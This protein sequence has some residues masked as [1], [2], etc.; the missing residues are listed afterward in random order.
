MGA[1]CNGNAV[2]FLCCA[3][4]LLALLH[5]KGQRNKVALYGRYRAE[6]SSAK[7]LIPAKIGWFVQELPSFLVPVLLIYQSGSLD[8]LGSKLLLFL[9]CG[10][11]FHRTLIYGCFTRGNAV[12]ISFVL[13]GFIFCT[14]NGYLQGHNLIYCT[15]YD[16]SWITDFRFLFGLVLFL[17]GMTFNIHSDHL[18]RKLRE[19]GEVTYKIPTGG[20]FE[21]V[22]V[23]NYFGEIVEWFG[24]SIASWTFPAFA[25]AI[26]SAVCLGSR[27]WHHHRFY[28]AKFQEYPKSRKV[29]IP[30]LF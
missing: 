25:F 17:L 23:P 12:E 8:N 26:F 14:C 27:A 1:Q 7:T 5:L 22:S 21:Y 10:H 9:F 30:F 2:L 11:Y 19:P 18:L 15:K 29:L 6:S 24:Y 3:L 13:K 28:V 4:I 16:E 20:L